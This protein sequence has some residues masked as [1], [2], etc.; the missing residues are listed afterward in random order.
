MN[1]QDWKAAYETMSALNEN[2]QKENERLMERKKQLEYALKKYAFPKNYF[3]ATDHGNHARNILGD[4]Q[5][6]F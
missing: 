4:T 6:E 5:N 3:L 2:L 1:Q